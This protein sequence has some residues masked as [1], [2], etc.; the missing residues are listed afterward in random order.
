MKNLSN[1]GIICFQKHIIIVKG[2]VMYYIIDLK[3]RSWGVHLYYGHTL[4]IFCNNLCKVMVYMALSSKVSHFWHNG[5]IIWINT[6]RRS[7][8]LGLDSFMNSGCTYK[9]EEKK[10]I[11]TLGILIIIIIMIIILLLILL[12]LKLKK[13]LI[14]L[15]LIIILKEER[16]FKE[17]EN[18][19]TN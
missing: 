3:L 1:F 16:H 10:L 4:C 6:T 12:K 5:G 13:L 11:I 7:G 18:Y 9:T 19:F 2:T 17:E 15:L 8:T 14:L